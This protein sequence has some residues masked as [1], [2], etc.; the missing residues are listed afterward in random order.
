MSC[1]IGSYPICIQ[2]LPPQIVSSILHQPEQYTKYKIPKL[3]ISEQKQTSYSG[4]TELQP[5]PLREGSASKV[6]RA[7]TRVSLHATNLIAPWPIR[8]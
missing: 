4:A 6:F 5:V 8:G 7:D 1:I 3:V 2:F